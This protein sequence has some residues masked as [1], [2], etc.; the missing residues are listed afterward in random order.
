MTAYLESIAVV[1][2]STAS[3]ASPLV[4]RRITPGSWAGDS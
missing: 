2:L 1:T 4:S 3:S